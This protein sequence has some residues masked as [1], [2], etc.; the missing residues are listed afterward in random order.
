MNTDLVE[1]IISFDADLNLGDLDGAAHKIPGIY[2]ILC[3]KNHIAYVGSSVNCKRRLLAH[4]SDLRNGKHFSGNMLCDFNKFGE[5]A[6]V[7]FVIEYC[8]AARLPDREVFWLQKFGSKM[9]YNKHLMASDIPLH[10]EN[11]I[12]PNSIISIANAN[13]WKPDALRIRAKNLF[14]G[15]DWSIYSIVSEDRIPLLI[16]KR[17]AVA[18]SEVA[19]SI[20]KNGNQLT[21]YELA[22]SA[23]VNYDT[24]FRKA[25]RK[26]PE[27]SWGKYTMVPK[28][29]ATEILAGTPINLIPPETHTRFRRYITEPS[30]ISIANKKTPVTKNGK[31]EIAEYSHPAGSVEEIAVARPKNKTWVPYGLLVAPTVAS[32]HN[33]FV[34]TRDL[35]GN[36]FDA[37]A[38]TV[39]LSV[40]ALGFVWYGARTWYTIALALLLIGYEAFCNLTRI[41][42]GLMG[43]GGTWNPTRFMGLVTDIFGS[44]THYTAIVLGGITALFLAAVQ[45][46][47][48]IEINKIK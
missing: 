28:D 44:G 32:V 36:W 47:A 24:I 16:I 9:L 19:E 13:G 38:L 41:Y 10:S 27:T 25:K 23:G 5:S 37:V 48:V 21:L 2:C 31:P 29:V 1:K 42:G 22:V 20:F 30:A 17:P 46:A 4:L 8:D 45:Y 26:F 15:E 3:V 33:M 35:S 12:D 14:P 39:V 7:P 18:L 6:F 40:S 43:V 11:G 34:V